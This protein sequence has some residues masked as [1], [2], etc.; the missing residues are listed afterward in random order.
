MAITDE[1]INWFRVSAENL[2]H[3]DKID[4]INIIHDK[5]LF[6]VHQN[7]SKLLESK[8]IPEEWRDKLTEFFFLIH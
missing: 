3:W 2:P 5:N 6:D 8:K 1:C 4:V 7:L